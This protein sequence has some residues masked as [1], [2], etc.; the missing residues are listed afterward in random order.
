MLK[1]LKD[2]VVTKEMPY[3]K[4]SKKY[5]RP[6]RTR[7][8]VRKRRWK[9]RRPL[10]QA[11]TLGKTLLKKFR[12]VD[13][14]EIDPGIATAAVHTF[15]ANSLYD[16]DKTGVGHQP[17]GFDQLM[18]FYNHYCVVGA[19]LK[20]TFI[21][22]YAGP[23][24]GSAVVGIE[25]SGST[26]PS[27]GLIDLYENSNSALKVMTNANSTQKV[28]IVKNV[29]VRKFLGQKPMSCDENSG[30][31][32]ANPAEEIYFHVFATGTDD[33]DQPLAVRVIVELDQIAV[34]HERKNIVGS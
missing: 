20:C 34:L 25:L 33:A 22:T 24:T 11:G 9:V 19:R 32:S 3:K 2:K 15:R 10:S 7:R 26:T 8:R 5:K 23:N 16:P 30:S 12:Y 1:W 18:S 27:S 21:S 17:L 29:S 6:S 31:A 4:Y 13:K 28:T 14:I